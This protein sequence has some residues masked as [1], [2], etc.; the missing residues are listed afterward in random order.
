MADQLPPKQRMKIPRQAMPEQDPAVRAC[1]FEEVNL[2]LDIVVAEKEAQRCLTCADPKCVSGCPVGVQIRDFVTL[3]VSGDYLGA[4]AKIREDNVL[5]AVTGRVC[6]Q[7]NQCEGAC[8]LSKKFT[9]LAIGNLERFVADYERRTGQVGLPD[10]APPTGKKVAIVGSGPAGLSC[11]GDLVLK[12]HEVTVFEALHEIGGVLVY[13]IPEFRLPKEIVRE[14]IDNMRKMGIDFQTNVVIGKTVTIDELMQ[15]EG[16]DAVFIATGAGLPRFLGIPGENLGGVYSANEF[17]TR[18]NLM[19]AYEPDEYETPIYDCRG[20]NVAVVGGGNTAMDAVRSA[21]R[22]GAATASIIYRRGRDE[23]PAR[24][25]EAHHAEQEGV[26]FLNLHNPV[27]FLGNDEGQLTGVRMIKMELG[28]PDESGRR[29]PSPVEGSETD[30]PIDV[31]IIAVGTGA[32]PLVQ[33]TTPDM[34]TNKRGYILADDE[35][36]RTTKEGVFAGGDIVSG[37]ATVILAMGAGRKAAASVHE[38]LAT[39]DWETG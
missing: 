38:F 30:I 4:A 20:K 35:T 33:S 39:G 34:E 29:S 7:E 24:A 16:Y 13:G 25:E 8:V 10:K 26:Q 1:N 21:K 14:E 37:A 18:V 2:G 28:E 36:M 5:P 11:A 23:M 32:N 12:G 19:K 31:A 9:S 22:L 17:L 27:E 15:E 6:P 3:V